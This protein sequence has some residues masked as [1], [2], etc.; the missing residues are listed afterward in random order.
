MKHQVPVAP[1]RYPTLKRQLWSLFKMTCP[2]LVTF[3][4]LLITLGYF[5]DILLG[6][7]HILFASI[8]A[9]A[10]GTYLALLVRW[11]NRSVQNHAERLAR[12][13]ES[14][15][16]DQTELICRWAP[17]GTLT[18]VNGAYARYFGKEKTELVG[19]NFLQYLPEEEREVIHCVVNNLTPEKPFATYTH[20]VIAPDGTLRWMEWTDRALFDEQGNIVELQ[21]VGRDITEQKRAEEEITILVRA[22]ETTPNAVIITDPKFAIRYVNPAFTRITGYLPEEAIGKNPRILKSGFHDKEF[23][24]RLYAA[25]ARGETFRGRLINRRKGT[26]VRSEANPV[27][28]SPE[29]HYWAEAVISPIHDSQGN[30]LGYLG[31]QND[32]TQQVLKEERERR[33]A[34]HDALLAEVA[35]ELQS[36]TPIPNRLVAVL[37]RITQQDELALTGEYLMW[38]FEEGRLTLSHHHGEFDDATL[39]DWQTLIAE[40]WFSNPAL[41]APM[42]IYRGSPRCVW[43]VPLRWM[44]HDTGLIFLFTKGD[45]IFPHDELIRHF[46]NRLGELIGGMV[47]SERSMRL[48]RQAKEQAE[49]L[50]QMRSE[51]LANMSHEIRT[52]MNGVLGMLRLLGE[53]PL[54]PEQREL[55]DTAQQSA[56][57]LMELLN[58]I[59][60]LAQYE[61][62]QVRLDKTPI[63][64]GN[65]LKEAV[66]MVLP[67][68]RLKGILARMEVSADQPL[69]VKG[70][71]L[72]LRQIVLNLLGNAIKFTHQGEVVARVKLLSADADTLNL[73]FEVQDTGIGIPQDKREVIFDPFRQVDG[74]TTRKYGGTGLGLAICKKLVELM[75]GTIGVESQE[76]VGSLFW[77]DLKLPRATV[78]PSVLVEQSQKRVVEQS[79]I[80]GL[81]VLV[82]EDNLVNQ[83][84]VRR[85]LEKWGVHCEIAENGLEVLEWLSREPFHLILMDCQMPRMD[86]FEAT[87]RIRAYEEHTGRHLHIPIIALTA[88]AMSEDRERCLQVGMDDYLSKPLKPELLYEKLVYWGKPRLESAQGVA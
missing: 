50:A 56:E 35:M 17:D 63:D 16:E 36:P 39:A 40:E 26:P 85:I 29:T 13:Y 78:P 46:M 20:C 60:S 28:F 76:G 1:L 8:I 4:V 31:I 44:G 87:R 5:L 77:F 70:D 45:Q 61:S 19:V 73:R 68:A 14:V 52:P 81:R 7:P 24:Q 37:K 3:I 75:G 80:V 22:L 58:D 88:N 53:T 64:I 84:V 11:V 48:M 21:S 82:A 27:P 12:L 57:H 69:Y 49:R 32:I 18:F 30:L 79:K 54:N 41:P 34:Q 51:F 83:K 9:I 43:A 15:V 71:P 47:I 62:G 65:L 59:L 74:S 2:V 25:L 66:N 42:K 33:R 86:G 10:V 6:T 55:L 72:R 23:Y 38:C 67:Q